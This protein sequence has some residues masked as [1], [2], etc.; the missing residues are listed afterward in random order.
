MI[1][2]VC[3]EVHAIYSSSICIKCG[4]FGVN[5]FVPIKVVSKV[6]R[7]DSIFL[8]TQ[9]IIPPEGT[10]NIYGFENIEERNLFN[11]LIKIPKVGSKTAL[12]ILSHFDVE[13]IKT[14]VSSKDIDSLSLVPGLGRKLSERVIFELRSR[15]RLEES[16]EKRELV[17]VLESLGYKRK[18]ILAS[19]KDLD[20]RTMGFEDAVKEAIR[21]LSGG[22][23]GK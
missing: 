15:I 18:D 2:F 3:G 17:E 16:L 10:P 5:V 1:D 21:R 4:S 11:L 7:G 13:Q 20:V 8:Y 12:S 22:K 6:K 14:I 19:I 9:L 23:F